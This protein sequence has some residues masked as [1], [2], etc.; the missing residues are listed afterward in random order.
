MK[1]SYKARA[2]SHKLTE[3][4]GEDNLFCRNLPEPTKPSPSLL[5][6]LGYELVFSACK[7]V[8]AR[9]G[10]FSRKDIVSEVESQ[11]LWDW[12]GDDPTIRR[13]VGGLASHGYLI[14]VK[15]DTYI[16]GGIK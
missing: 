7:I 13:Y 1:I 9:I 14:K 8:Y 2:Q 3:Y 6:S 15:R 11:L 12:K 16:I 5:S 10:A 4:G